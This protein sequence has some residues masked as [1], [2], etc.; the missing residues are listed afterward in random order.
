MALD[1]YD[2]LKAAIA[3]HLDD[4]GLSSQ[5]ED[6]IDLAEARHKREIRIREMLTRASLTVDDRYV[7]FPTGYLEGKTLR[8]LTTP[9]TVLTYR[10]LHEMNR[11]RRETSGKPLYFTEHAQFE[12]DVS[13]DTAYSGEI[14]YFKSL[15]ALSDENTSNAILIR[16]PDAYLYAALLASAPFLVNDERL[17]VWGELYLNA[18]DALNAVDNKRIGPLIARAAGATP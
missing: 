17:K 1:S 10:N 6:F 8:L 18:K 4:D 16:A 15:T 11:V 3:D 13:P 14:I 5:I 9:V 7:D 2:G 12:F